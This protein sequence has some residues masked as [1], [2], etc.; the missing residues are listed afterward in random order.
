MDFLSINVQ[1]LDQI[2][3]QLFI[4]AYRVLSYR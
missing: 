2:L 4:I 3:D 1:R